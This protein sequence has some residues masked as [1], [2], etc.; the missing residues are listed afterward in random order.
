MCVCVY[1]FAPL[2]REQFGNWEAERVNMAVHVCLS[3]RFLPELRTKELKVK[4]SDAESHTFDSTVC[5][6]V[7]VFLW[8]VFLYSDTDR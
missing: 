1:P 5:V 3:E 6:C 2:M 8:C 4:C 7:C